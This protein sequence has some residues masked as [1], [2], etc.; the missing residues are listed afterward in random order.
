MVHVQ[1]KMIPILAVFVVTAIALL[2][3][4]QIA[5][6]RAES[7]ALERYCDAPDAHIGY[8]RRIL[9][10]TQPAGDDARRPYIIAAKLIYLVPQRTDESVE[11]YLRRI[12]QRIVATCR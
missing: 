8:L 9:S 4:F 10:E 11:S 7:V 12:E 6:H 5:G 2:L 1:R 3:V